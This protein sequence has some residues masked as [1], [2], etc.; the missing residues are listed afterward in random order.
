MEND[1]GSGSPM[2]SSLVMAAGPVVCESG[3]MLYAAPESMTP[4]SCLRTWCL[5]VEC[6]RMFR[7][8]EMCR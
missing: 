2:M 3:E 5:G 1:S 7:C 8:V 4:L 6:R